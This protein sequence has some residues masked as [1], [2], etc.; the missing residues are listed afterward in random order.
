MDSSAAVSGL[1]LRFFE[2][3]THRQCRRLRYVCHYIRNQYPGLTGG[4]PLLVAECITA[5]GRYCFGVNT[6]MC[7]GVFDPCA[8]ELQRD[9]R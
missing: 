5:G 2:R 9:T 7:A 4:S 6:T 8:P 3:V 1:K